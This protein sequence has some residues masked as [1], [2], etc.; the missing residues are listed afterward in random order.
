MLIDNS[1]W[2]ITGANK[3][4]GEALTRK[5]LDQGYKVAAA[6][7]RPEELADLFGLHE[8]L[9]PV[10][11]DLNSAD[12]IKSAVAS[13][14]EKF[15]RIDV[16]AN[17]AGYGL[18]GYFE[19][20]SEQQIR[21]QM[22][23]NFFGTVRL[24]REVLPYMREARRGYVISVSST[25]GIKAVEG[26]SVYAA[27]KFALEGWMEGLNLEVSRFGIECM[28]VEPG[29][30]RTN[31]FKEGSSFAFSELELDDYKDVRKT[32]HGHFVG[33]DG[34][35]DGNPAKF[36]ENLLKVMNSDNPPLRFLISKS[37]VPA[38]DEY[39]KNRYAE[40]EAWKDVSADTAFDE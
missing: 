12:E 2:L 30:F 16:L 17:V 40:F 22:E 21:A 31:F 8:N 34:K 33:W 36:A 5:L 14:I 39:Y 9:L 27:S 18:L 23:T 37:A 11:I 29:A 10:K 6:V 35:Q 7:R 32:L 1:V 25:S 26:S 28:I 24:T 19:E 20:I 3:G 4:L 38:I 15:G 13:V